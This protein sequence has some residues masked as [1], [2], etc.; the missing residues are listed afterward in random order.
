MPTPTPTPA[1]SPPAPFDVNV[2]VQQPTASTT[3]DCEGVEDGK[4][5]YDCLGECGGDATE[6]PR[7]QDSPADEESSPPGDEEEAADPCKKVD[8]VFMV[9]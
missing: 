8:I 1:P 2:V 6:G 7:C 3:T 9:E 5:T 4:K